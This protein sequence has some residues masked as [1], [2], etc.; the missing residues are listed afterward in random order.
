M[1]RVI[2]ILY[3]LPR[4]APRRC[5][6]PRVSN[7]W[8]A[9]LQNSRNALFWRSFRAPDPGPMISAG[10][11]SSPAR[12]AFGTLGVKR[13]ANSSVLLRNVAHEVWGSFH[14]IKETRNE[15][16]TGSHI[17]GC[18][19]FCS[20]P[21]PPSLRRLAVSC[22]GVGQQPPDHL[23]PSVEHGQLK[24]PGATRTKRRVLGRLSMTPAKSC[25]REPG[26]Q[27]KRAPAGKE[28]GEL[29]RPRA[30]RFLAA[31]NQTYRNQR[32]RHSQR[33]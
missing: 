29:G 6:A 28:P 15:C 21:N 24:L 14:F 11:F 12:S 8:M 3:F 19:L 4:T 13:V 17:A 10:R 9:I 33:C 20:S 32:I 26:R 5:G 7:S 30:N 16:F 27:G 25:C 31:G 18:L 1:G 23:R 2:K 22:M